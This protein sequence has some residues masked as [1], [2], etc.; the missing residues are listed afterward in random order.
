MGE[1]G[2]GDTSPDFRF[3]GPDGITYAI[4]LYPGCDYCGTPIGIIVYRFGPGSEFWHEHLPE[5]PWRRYSPTTVDADFMVPIVDDETLAA[6]IVEHTG[7]K[8][9]AEDDDYE[10]LSD[11]LADELQHALA[12]AVC[13][14]F[15]RWK[16]QIAEHKEHTDAR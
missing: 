2:C 11:A 1:C 4:Q 8:G 10:N 15:D 6:S 12:H 13:S 3:P 16:V 5:P 7:D 14:V 9:F